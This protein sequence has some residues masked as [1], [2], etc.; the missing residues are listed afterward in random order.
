M[1]ANFTINIIFLNNNKTHTIA[2]ISVPRTTINIFT[3]YVMFK[4]INYLPTTRI[5]HGQ[6]TTRRMN[7]NSNFIIFYYRNLSFNRT[8]KCY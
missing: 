1:Q 7:T 5:A 2:Y 3:T 6:P 4:C 8:A